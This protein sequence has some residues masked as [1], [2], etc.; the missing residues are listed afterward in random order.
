MVGRILE[1]LGGRI[2]ERLGRILERLGRI[3]DR[4][5]RILGRILGR[6][7][8]FWDVKTIL[9]RHEGFHI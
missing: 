4:L 6:G 7:H 8:G 3:L 1:R 2:L 5:G 9:A